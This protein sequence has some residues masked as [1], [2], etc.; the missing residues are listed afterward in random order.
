MADASSRRRLTLLVNKHDPVG[1]YYRRH[2][3][4]D[5]QT[6]HFTQEDPIGLAGGLN[7]YGFAGGDPVNFRD[8]FGLWPLLNPASW[9]MPWGEVR[10]LPG[11]K[12]GS[13]RLRW[14]LSWIAWGLGRPLRVHGGDR[15]PERNAD[16]QGDPNSPHLRGE[17]V[18]LQIVGASHRETAHALYHSSARRRLGVRLIYHQP[19]AILPEHSHLDLV[20]GP[21]QQE[22]PRVPILF[23]VPVPRGVVF[24]QP[25]PRYVPLVDPGAHD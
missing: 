2:R 17:A 4:V 23:G 22:Q 10:Y 15:T 1:T 21:D 3:V 8:P 20:R 19:G 25:V 18:D 5:A 24:I 14:A 9:G 11:V 13:V 6:G 7:L 16:V 12:V